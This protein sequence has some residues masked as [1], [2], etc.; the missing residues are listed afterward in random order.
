M[1]DTQASTPT[2]EYIVPDNQFIADV[3]RLSG[4]SARKCFQCGTCTVSCNVSYAKERDESFPRQQILRT[5]WGLKGKVLNDPAIW[6]CYQCNDC[7]ANCPR[8]A[9]AGDVLAALRALAIREYAVPRFMGKLYNEPR[10]LPLIFGIPAVVL[11]ALVFLFQGMVF[12]DGPIV[13]KHFI[14]SIY[15]EIAGVIVGG[16]VVLAAGLGLFRY[17]G[18]VQMTSALQPA[19]GAVLQ[20]PGSM[21][22]SAAAGQSLES[23]FIGTMGDVGT[24]KDFWTCQA[25]RLRPFGHLAVFY[26]FPLLLVAT[27]ISLL[28]TFTG[29]IPQERPLTDPMKIA[30]NIGGVLALIGILVLMYNRLQTKTGAW[31]K[32]NYFD[33]LLL[34]LLLLNVGTG[35]LM[36][37]VRLANQPTLAYSLYMAHLVFVFSLF[38]YLPYGKLAHLYYRIAALTVIRQ[39]GKEGPGKLVILLPAGAA[40][41]IGAA[42][43]FVGVV[44]VLIWAIQAALGG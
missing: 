43:A 40:V 1:V 31:G 37:I 39:G 7:S 29:I 19:L 42:A 9:K 4:E 16:L 26:G 17:W 2:A 32:A 25:E 18:D 27:A 23:A 13:Y 5:Q 44:F 30:G 14:P 10:Y 22:A 36:E 8:G 28:Y 24:H 35:L 12:P 41:F 15:V 6:A 21:A 3:L 38:F 11:L 33:W 20:G 34:W